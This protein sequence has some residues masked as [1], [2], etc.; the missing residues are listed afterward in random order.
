MN[1]PQHSA[2][3]DQPV[4]SLG[5]LDFVGGSDPDFAPQADRRPLVCSVPWMKSLLPQCRERGGQ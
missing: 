4:V 1:M 5:Y 3:S 2:A